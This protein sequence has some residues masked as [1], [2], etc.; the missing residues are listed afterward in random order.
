MLL[1]LQ[2]VELSFLHTL[3]DASNSFLDF[4]FEAITFLGEQYVYIVII[5]LVYF[6]IDK[7]K[8]ENI[9]YAIFTSALVNGVVKLF[10][11]RPRPFSPEHANPV[12]PAREE[13]AT[14]Y[15]FPSG[16]TQNSAVTYTSV[17][18]QF[19]KRWMYIAATILVVA[20]GFSRLWLGVHYPTDVLVGGILGVGV[21]F[22]ASFLTSKFT[23]TFKSKMILFSSTALVFLPF[24]IY[25]YV[26]YKL[27]LASVGEDELYVYYK[28]NRD[29]II[30]YGLLLGAL[31]A[32]VIE[33]KFVNFE[34]TTNLRLRILRPL[35]ALVFALGTYFGLN[36]IFKAINPYCVELDFLRYLLV[37]LVGIGLYPLITKNLLFKKEQKAE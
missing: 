2:D 7:R 9:V 6:S 19:R 26:K 14:G 23:K 11:R 37:P 3:R 28:L 31:I 21:A 27:G 36:L 29:I 35:F 22:F 33:Y 30:S 17:A 32:F 12:T 24:T 4:L 5:I 10:V 20:I 8:A 34:N 13:T 15:S 18:L 16:H 1:T 25:F